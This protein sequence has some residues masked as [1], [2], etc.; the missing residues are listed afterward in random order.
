VRKVAV[1][2]SKSVRVDST[3]GAR[4][5]RTDRSRPAG[6]AWES[7]LVSLAA[8]TGPFAQDRM[9]VA[10]SKGLRAQVEA[11]E[12]CVAEVVRRRDG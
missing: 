8:C 12:G 11:C 4:S 3:Y 10:T 1:Q 9:G 5:T 6:T 2:K 7:L